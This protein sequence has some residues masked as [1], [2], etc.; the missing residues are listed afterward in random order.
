MYHYILL[1]IFCRL[2]FDDLL[3]NTEPLYLLNVITMKQITFLM[4]QKLS[5]LK[6]LKRE[7]KLNS[8]FVIKKTSGLVFLMP[9]SHK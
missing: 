2:L 8:K 6:K 1:K 5:T 4:N 9:K 7:N 3:K